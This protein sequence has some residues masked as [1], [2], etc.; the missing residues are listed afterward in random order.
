MSRKFSA[1]LQ[2]Y[3]DWSILPAALATLC[4][5]INE[6]V[7]VDGAYDWMVPYLKETGRDPERSDK[8]V[9][10]ALD[11]SGIPYRAIQ[12]TWP[13]QLVKRSTGYAACTHDLIFRVDAD[14]LYFF[15]DNAFESALTVGAAV[16]CMDMPLYLAPGKLLTDRRSNNNTHQNF[17]FDRSKISAEQ[18]LNYLWLVLHADK[19]PEEGRRPLPVYETPV[20]FNAHLSTWRTADTSSNRTGY[21]VTN[22]MRAH[23][24]P[25][26]ASLAGKP[27]DDFSKLFAIVQPSDFLSILETNL[28]S[29]GTVELEP[30]DVVV[31]SHVAPEREA[32]FVSLYDTFLASLVT[33]NTKIQARRQPFVPGLSINLDISTPASRAVLLYD[34]ILC[35]ETEADIAA[36]QAHILTLD[37]ATSTNEQIKLPFRKDKNRLYV[38]V[39]KIDRPEILRQAVVIKIWPTAPDPVQYLSVV[40]TF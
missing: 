9:Y 30:K 31:P 20:A 11:A 27:L 18:H 1:Y 26:F 36:A 3:N 34:N 4:S 23:G 10:D 7:V 16:A 13:N 12:R 17:F 19:L 29:L 39:P 40:R 6:L 35:I 8:R 15:D 32:K 28:L 38:E 14:E 2:I 37:A 25:W 22:W 33:L 21:Y 24:V 5:R